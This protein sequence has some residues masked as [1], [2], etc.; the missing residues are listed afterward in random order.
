[1]LPRHPGFGVRLALALAGLW[2]GLSG[3]PAC[4]GEALD[5]ASATGTARVESLMSAGVRRTFTVYSPAASPPATGWPVLIAF[6]GA[7]GDGPGMRALMG[8]EGAADRDGILVVYPDAAPDTRGTWALGCFQCTWADA[9]GVDDYRFARDLVDTLAARHG[10]DRRRVYVAGFSLGGS[11]ANDLT[12]RAGDLVAGA[13]VVASLPSAD[14]LP[15]C[16]PTRAH[17]IAIMVGDQ[18][19]NIP[20]TGGGTYQ[21]L[22]AEE[23]ARRWSAWDGCSGAPAGTLLPDRDGDGRRVAVTTYAPCG[24][25]TSVRLYRVTGGG[26]AWPNG[27]L[28]ASGE[29]FTLFFGSGT[30]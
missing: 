5:P 1:M 2:G 11:F 17:T 23:D 24:D 19:P 18:D 29:L 28:D 20:W 26:H 30:A 6:H 3:L 7:G 15:G 14:E 8:V 21:Y 16:G 25:G 27:D 22:G 13:A 10:V 12:C 9:Q 4:G